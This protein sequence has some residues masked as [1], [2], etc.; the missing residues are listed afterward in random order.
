MANCTVTAAIMLSVAWAV[1][2]IAIDVMGMN[3]DRAYLAGLFGAFSGML[4][5]ELIKK[6]PFGKDYPQ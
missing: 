3:G 2:V 4:V 6:L 1:G 5:V